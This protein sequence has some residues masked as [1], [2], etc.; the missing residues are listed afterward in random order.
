M[1][2]YDRFFLGAFIVLA[3]VAGGWIADWIDPARVSPRS[4]IIRRTV[5]AA[6]CVYALARV[7]ALDALLLMDARYSA[8]RWLVT[9]V[10]AGRSIAGV[11]MPQYLPRQTV[12]PWDGTLT[13]DPADLER[14]KPDYVIVNLPYARRPANGARAAF[15]EQLF[16]GTAG[17]RRV[18]EFHPTVPFSP[19]A[20]ESRFTAGVED[21]FSNL[22]KINPSIEVYSRASP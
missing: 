6:V 21:P 12:V 2:F 14:A 15:Y 16:N 8:E 11:G 18:A 13:E 20:Y 3:I 22:S 1:Y 17:Y 10:P 5:V 9:Q 4:L 19:L 7:V